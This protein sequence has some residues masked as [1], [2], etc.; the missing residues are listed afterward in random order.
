LK[1]FF[2]ALRSLAYENSR[3]LST[4]THPVE[5]TIIT[6]SSG[7]EVF[8]LT[9][10]KSEWETLQKKLEPRQPKSKKRTLPTLVKLEGTQTTSD[11]AQAAID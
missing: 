5:P 10:T 3:L 6:T 8:V 11:D 2:K 1:L 7:E 9:L 4:V